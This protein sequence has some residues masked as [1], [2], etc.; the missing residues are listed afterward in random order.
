[1]NL[2]QLKAKAT[3]ILEGAK[4]ANRSL[5]DLENVEL[6][7]IKA[8]IAKLEAAEEQARSASAA[9]AQA[10]AE[11]NRKAAADAEAA[12]SAAAAAAQ[13]PD[14]YK[15]P[16]NEYLRSIAKGAADVGNKEVIDDV[17]RQFNLTSPI[18]AAHQN[19]QRRSTG[20]TFSF[21]KITSGGTGYRKTEGNAGSADTVSAASM[22]SVS[23]ITYSGQKILLSQEALDDYA[24]DVAQEVIVIGTSQS[25]IAFGNDCIKAMK[26]AFGG[27]YN[28]SGTETTP[29][30]FTQTDSTAWA[31][32]DLIGA[33]YDIPV[34]NR[35]GVKFVMHPSTAEAI[36]G[37]LTVDKSPQ[38]AW[39][40]LT[41]ENI[42]EDES[43]DTDVVFVGNLTLA[44]AIGMKVPVRVWMQDVS[45]GK[46]VEVQP[47]LA[48][49]LRDSSAIAAR[50]LADS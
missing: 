16:K 26:T 38:A 17:V 25:S 22:V 21:T 27:V 28:G 12:R 29:P 50:Q 41:K 8:E 42:V 44:L 3:A 19:V 36:V 4:T 46:N 32:S 5:T 23:F 47:R 43:M 20:N 49:A 2:A 30:T 31:L 14:P 37:L 18:F 13:K 15:M 48:V 9:S 24:A 11:A 33:Y 6:A 10:Q 35:Y 39:I 40:G 45:E 34:R 7:N 1:M